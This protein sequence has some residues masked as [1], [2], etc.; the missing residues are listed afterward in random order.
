MDEQA[1]PESARRVDAAEANRMAQELNNQALGID[2]PVHEI[3]TENRTGGEDIDG[4]PAL[5]QHEA[6]SV[7]NAR[8]VFPPDVDGDVTIGGDPE[9]QAALREEENS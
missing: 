1:P 4:Q 9:S 3:P 5:M 6:N 7:V 8:S 2:A